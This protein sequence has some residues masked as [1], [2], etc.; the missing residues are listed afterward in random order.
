MEAIK[1][2]EGIKEKT[3]GKMKGVIGWKMNKIKLIAVITLV[4]FIISTIGSNLYALPTQVNDSKKYK[5]VF[6]KAKSVIDIE[7][8][9]I[10]ASKDVNSDITV[11]NI[12]DLHCHPQVQKNISKIIGELATK[13]NL[14]KVYVEGGYGEIDTSWIETI[15]DE[16]IKEEVI[17]KLLKEGILTGSEYYKLTSKGSGVELKGLDEERIHKDNLKRLSWIIGKQEKYKEVMKDIDKE[18]GLL[19]KEY[20]NVRNKRFS[21]SYEQYLLGEID[22]KRFYRQV[23]KYVKEINGNPQR[24]NNITSIKLGD[25]PNII[26][27]VA[28][29]NNANNMKEVTGQ[30]QMLMVELKNR[31]P[32]GV[33]KKMLKETDNLRDSQKVVEIAL[34][35]SEKANINLEGRY[36]QLKNFL[37][38]NRINKEINPIELVEEERELIERV[39]WALSYNKEEYEI[40]Y[41]S[42]F[43][44]YFKEYL[45][46]KLTEADWQYYEKGFKKFENIYAKYASVNKIEEIA[47][48]FKEL[49]KYY[50]INDRRNDIFVGKMLTG[51]EPGVIEEEGARQEEEI[52]KSSKEVIVA[53][54]GGFHSGALEEILAKEKVNTIVITPSIYADVEVATKKYKEVIEEQSK[55]IQHQALAYTVMSSIADTDKRKIIISVIK[56]LLKDNKNL[57][58]ELKQVFGDKV[59]IEE[60]GYEE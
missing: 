1:G 52:L 17:E 48:D 19:E 33:Y 51:V 59:N 41:I 14:K 18:I 12:Q 2:V 3:K 21:R 42:D 24:Y 31:V 20:V 11:V 37:E 7:S 23:M 54:T 43:N 47:E 50:R 36:K 6:N 30:L 26:K 49:N 13:Y 22:T 44:K 56:D 60:Y 40:T 15:R 9:K 46:Y 8:G 58:E 38:A 35:L 57:I 5:D 53:I 39:R 25:Y 28:L 10:T 27:Y 55:Q 45:G 34:R 16:K 4:S 32:Y 29:T